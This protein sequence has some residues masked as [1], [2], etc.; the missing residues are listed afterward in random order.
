MKEKYIYFNLS[1]VSVLV[2]KIKQHV[3]KGVMVG[4][5]M[6]FKIHTHFSKIK[7]SVHTQL[8]I[9]LVFFRCFKRAVIQTFKCKKRNKSTNLQCHLKF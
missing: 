7:Q 6:M 3:K 1:L 5:E 8:I 4:L 9:G 2:D